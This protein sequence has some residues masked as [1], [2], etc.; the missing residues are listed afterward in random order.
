M[1]TFRCHWRR[2]ESS[3]LRDDY[4]SL[5]I[6]GSNARNNARLRAQIENGEVLSPG[7]VNA[8]Y[9]K[10]LITA[11]QKNDLLKQLK[12]DSLY[13]TPKDP[14][15]KSI[16]N[17]RK[18]SYKDRMLQAMGYKVD[19]LTNA[20]VKLNA[21][22]GPQP[23]LSKDKAQLLAGQ[24]QRD[25]L[26]EVNSIVEQ[27]PDLS[28]SDLQAV[29]S[30]RLNE[31][32]KGIF[33]KDGKY[34]IEPILQRNANT[35]RKYTPDER[36]YFS[37]LIGSSHATSFYSPDAKDFSG[38]PI[39]SDIKEQFNPL[40]GDTVIDSDQAESFRQMYVDEGVLAPSLVKQADALGMTPL[41]LL[42]SQLVNHGLSPVS[43]QEQKVSVGQNASNMYEGHQLLMQ[44]GFP[45]RGAAWL[46]G[47]IAQESAWNGQRTWGEVIGD[48]SDRNGGLVSWMDDAERNHYRLTNIEKRLGKPIGQA[49]DSEQIQAMIAEMKVRNPEAYA[50]FMNPRSTERQLSEH[51][52][53]IGV[54]ATKESVINTHDK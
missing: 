5:T 30:K 48:G 1:R 10:G 46:S 15:V 28:E 36:A 8:A 9:E 23:L 6:D 22:K 7:P 41:A 14:G 2:R 18:K 43:P 38:R 44:A 17:D 47:N 12:D 42:Q 20:L 4:D 33:G 37:G 51:R 32:S 19:G 13:Q 52:K 50:I 29:V 26:R 11:E 39:T 49:T 25:L 16:Y 27:N 35:K 24:M 34:P 54:T 21:E 40:R 31:W 3:R 53:H 45:A